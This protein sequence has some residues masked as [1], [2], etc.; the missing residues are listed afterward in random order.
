MLSLL[1]DN[2]LL[3]ETMAKAAK[4]KAEEYTVENIGNKWLRT[5]QGSL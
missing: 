2:P 3:L 4:V 5:W 1:M